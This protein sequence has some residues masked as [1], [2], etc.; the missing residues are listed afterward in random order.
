MCRLD[1]WSTIL[2]TLKFYF[3]FM[4]RLRRQ[5][6]LILHTKLGDFVLLFPS[7]LSP[8]IEFWLAEML[9]F[10]EPQLSHRFLQ[11]FE[12]LNPSQDQLFAIVPILGVIPQ[13]TWLLRCARHLIKKGSF[14][15]RSLLLLS[16]DL[17]HCF[18]KQEVWSRTLTVNCWV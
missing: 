1:I 17:L 2:G 3:K 6:L 13:E 9:P 4:V 14:L 15:C 10:S 5:L 16:Y 12:V 8:S 11:L 18:W 7:L